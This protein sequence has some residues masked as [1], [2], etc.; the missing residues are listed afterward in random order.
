MIQVGQKCFG[1]RW[2]GS[3]DTEYFEIVAIKQRLFRLL[4]DDFVMVKSLS[5]GKTYKAEIEREEDNLIILTSLSGQ[6]TARVEWN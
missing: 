4:G 5:D 3:T 6:F 2:N 1:W